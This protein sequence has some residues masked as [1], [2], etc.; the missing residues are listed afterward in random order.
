MAKLQLHFNGSFALK[1]D[2]ISRL[3]YAANQ[4]QG[5]N[6]SLPNLMEKTSLGNGK[7]GRVKSWA[8]RAGL[9]KNNHPSPEGEIVLKLDPVLESTITDWLMHFYLSFGDRGLKT[10]PENPADWGG[11]SYFVYT[12]LPR[13]HKFTKEELLYHSTSIFEEESK[14]IA[15]RINYILRAYT[16]FTALASCK[17]LTQEKEQYVSGYPNLP[18]SYLLGYFLAKLWERDFQGE[19][20]VL[21]ESILNKKMGLAAVL[22]ITSEALQEQLNALEAYGIIEQRRAVPPFQVIPRWDNPLTLLEKAY[23]R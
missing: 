8:V 4:D 12:F 1:K 10:T 18:N 14:V 5:L 23:D 7:V 16:E 20:S 17:F 3:I 21:T 9:I 6:D 13:Y 19:G 22:G 2:E 11:W 15:N